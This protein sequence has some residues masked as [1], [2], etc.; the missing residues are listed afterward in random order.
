MVQSSCSVK[1]GKLN[2]MIEVGALWSTS[3]VKNTGRNDRTGPR[4]SLRSPRQ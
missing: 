2:E 1:N 3:P 4:Y